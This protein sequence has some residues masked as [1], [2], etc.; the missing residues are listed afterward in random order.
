MRNPDEVRLAPRVRRELES[1][2]RK[3]TMEARLVQRADIILRCADGQRNSEIADALRIH[4]VSVSR[5]RH[6]FI[7]GGIEALHDV[8]CSGKPRQI[9]DD[10]DRTTTSRSRVMRSYAGFGMVAGRRQ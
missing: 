8:P 7:K 9:T 1:W 6:R 3:G 10:V 2:R 4:P 5:W